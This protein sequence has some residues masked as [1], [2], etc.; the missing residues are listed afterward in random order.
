MLF[1]ILAFTFDRSGFSGRKKCQTPRRPRLLD[2]SRVSWHDRSLPP[3]PPPSSRFS[4]GQTNNYLSQF[5]CARGGYLLLGRESVGRFRKRVLGLC[6][7]Q[8]GF[9]VGAS[10]FFPSGAVRARKCA[11]PGTRT[12]SAPRF[13]GRGGSFPL[14]N[15]RL[16]VPECTIDER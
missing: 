8:A 1:Y 5:F 16:R 6:L 10:S 13:G 14:I 7:A 2:Y 9:I 12:R 11:E 4:I 3:L 15:S